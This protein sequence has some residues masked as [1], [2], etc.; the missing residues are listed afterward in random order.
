MIMGFSRCGSMI[1]ECQD[2]YKIYETGG[3]KVVALQG[4]SFIS[5]AGSIYAIMGPSGSGK[6][7]LLAIIGGLLKPSAGRVLIGDTEITKLDGKELDRFRLRNIG[8][9]FQFFNLI[10]N[11]TVRENVEL[12]MVLLGVKREVRKRRVK[13]LLSRLGI[14]DKAD[15]VVNKLSGGEQQ[16]VAIAVALANDPPVIL[17]DEPTGELDL[18][19]TYIISELLR[20]LAKE[21][22]K[23]V[24][25]VTHD[26]LVASYSDV[27]SVL[28][29]GMIVATYTRDEFLAVSGLSK[30]DVDVSKLIESKKAIMEKL[31][32]V[33]ERYLNGELGE[34]EYFRITEILKSKLQ[35]IDSILRKI[36]LGFR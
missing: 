28:E 11:L 5:R 23:I 2:L 8:F 26:P 22:N 34:K 3:V 17:A 12:P 10:S 24:I 18:V 31:Q 7:T 32:R 4:V 20:E 33:K 27:I 16:R 6:T 19:N 21:L 36:R 13:E 15:I 35:E 9:V 14:S 29:D 1:L 25:V 30:R